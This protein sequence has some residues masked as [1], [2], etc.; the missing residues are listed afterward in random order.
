MENYVDFAMSENSDYDFIARTVYNDRVVYVPVQ[1]KELPPESICSK[2]IESEPDKLT[3]YARSDDLIVAYHLNRE[4]NINMKTL[5]IPKLNIAGIFFFG[6]IS[7][8]SN[9]WVMYGGKLGEFGGGK[10]E[11]PYA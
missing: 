6:K 5:E 1:T 10:Y 3:K 7:S 4:M 8:P 2:S 9:R 11:L